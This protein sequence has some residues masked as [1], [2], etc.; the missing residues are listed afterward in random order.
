MS[1]IVV[2]GPLYDKCMPYLLED[3][4]EYPHKILSTWKTEDT[5]KLEKLRGIG[6]YIVLNDYPDPRTAL[7][8]QALTTKTGIDLA[9]SLGY[10]HILRFRTD[11]HCND[12]SKLISIYETYD[13]DKLTFITWYEHSN[14]NPPHIYHA[15]LMDNTVYGPIYK[16]YT[17]FNVLGSHEE[18]RYSEKFFQE[19]YFGIENLVYDNIRGKVTLSIGDLIDKGITFIFTKPGREDWGEL[20]YDYTHC[21]SRCRYI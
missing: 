20:L 7:N 11:I 12:I 9:K 6:F 18:T 14:H 8:H 19:M 16:M 2:Q 3:Y 17:Y 5:E 21:S 10:T 1:C 15:Y 4:K 13:K